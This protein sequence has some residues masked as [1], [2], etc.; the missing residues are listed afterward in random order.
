MPAAPSSRIMNRTSA[1]MRDRPFG[2]IEALHGRHSVLAWLRA[3]CPRAGNVTS[4]MAADFQPGFELLHAERDDPV[5]VADA[6]GDERRRP[7]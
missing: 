6:G 4:S 7:R 2:Q 3:G 5:A 1:L